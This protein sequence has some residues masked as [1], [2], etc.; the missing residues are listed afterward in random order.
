[1]LLG[2]ILFPSDWLASSGYATL[3]AFVAVNTLIYVVLSVAKILPPVHLGQWLYRVRH[4]RR[5]REDRSIRPPGVLLPVAP[6]F[7]DRS[8]S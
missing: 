1:M 3:T 2:G 7:P 4:P 5:R 8:A 6:S